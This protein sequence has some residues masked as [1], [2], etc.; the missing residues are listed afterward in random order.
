MKSIKGA[1]LLFILI[2]GGLAVWPG[3]AT[4][5]LS[6][7]LVYSTGTSP[8]RDYDRQWAVIPMVD[9]ENDRFYVRDLSAGLKFYNSEDLKLAV[10]FGY[11]PTNFDGSDSGD[12]RLKRLDS[13]HEGLMAGVDAQWTSPVGHFSLSLS[14]DISGHSQGLLGRLAYLYSLDFGTV[15]FVPQV[16]SYWASGAYNDY[17]YGVSRKEARKSGLAAYEAGAAF[18]PFL[19]LTIDVVLDPEEHWEIFCYGEAVS[20][21]SAVK[22]SPMVGRSSTSSLT[23]GL[24]Y[25]F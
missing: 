22:N 17:Y 12:R 23:T 18:S 4:A 25:T 7:G 1:H 20:L 10:F 2:L 6:L 5:E 13:R 8:Y 14:G 24:T 19:G 21:P 3:R 11:D 15:E 16:G 9:F